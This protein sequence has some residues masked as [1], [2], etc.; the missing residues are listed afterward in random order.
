MLLFETRKPEQTGSS[1]KCSTRALL[2]G[3]LFFQRN[4][5]LYYSHV[6]PENLKP[7]QTCE[8][9]SGSK[10]KRMYADIIIELV[11]KSCWN[12]KGHIV[13]WRECSTAE[14]LKYLNFEY[15][16]YVFQD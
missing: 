3:L 2:F 5:W 15:A 12:L 4:T 6:A 16:N 10:L 1:R 14:N 13:V 7:V 11:K 8:N 9:R